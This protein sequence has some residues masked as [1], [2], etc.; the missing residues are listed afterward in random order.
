MTD[1]RKR[2]AKLKQFARIHENGD[3]FLAI[4]NGKGALEKGRHFYF[5][6]ER[7]QPTSLILR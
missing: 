5:Y 7:A 4:T 6:L 3:K 1:A 2:F